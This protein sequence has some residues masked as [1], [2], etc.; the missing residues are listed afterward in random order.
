MDQLVL[1][2]YKEKMKKKNETQKVRY[3]KSLCMSPPAVPGENFLARHSKIS[4]RKLTRG[5]SGHTRP[6]AWKYLF[7]QNTPFVTACR[8]PLL[9]QLFLSFF[10]HLLIE[11]LEIDNLL[12]LAYQARWKNI[13]YGIEF[14]PQRQ[15]CALRVQRKEGK[16]QGVLK[17]KMPHRNV[18]CLQDFSLVGVVFG[19]NVNFS[20]SFQEF[21]RAPM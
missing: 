10:W 3:Q 16:R 6:R 12:S 18:A 7:N 19:H 1:R 13:S 14:A 11:D 8:L 9:S 17:L 2:N 15:C 5:T 4:W 20:K 21:Q